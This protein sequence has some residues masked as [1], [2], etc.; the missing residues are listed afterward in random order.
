MKVRERPFW[1]G[2]CSQ[3]RPVL[4]GQ[5]PTSL[6]SS[7]VSLSNVSRPISDTESLRI[8]SRI[9]H[10]ELIFL[11]FPFYILYTS[12]C[13]LDCKIP[14]SISV[15]STRSQRLEEQ[16]CILFIYFSQCNIVPRCHVDLLNPVEY[17]EFGENLIHLYIDSFHSALFSWIYFK[18][19][20]N[21]HQ[22]PAMYQIGFWGYQMI[23]LKPLCKGLCLTWSG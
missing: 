13:Q 18:K 1:R 14:F 12:H 4:L 6:I 10:S 23:T 11:V 9:C 21:D 15:F 2:F 5:L 19:K 7:W 17:L 8:P 3:N 20:K 16:S 22:A